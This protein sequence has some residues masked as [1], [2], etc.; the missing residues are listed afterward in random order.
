MNLRPERV[1]RPKWYYQC[2]RVGTVSP[3]PPDA[4]DA[5]EFLIGRAARSGASGH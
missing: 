3:S 4:A 1:S 5:C 2:P